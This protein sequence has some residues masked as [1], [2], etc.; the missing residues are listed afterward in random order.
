MKCPEC[1]QVMSIKMAIKK[2]NIIIFVLIV[3]GNS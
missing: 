1:N 2:V 3:V